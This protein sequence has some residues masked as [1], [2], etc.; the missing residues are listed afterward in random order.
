MIDAALPSEALALARDYD[1]AIDL[2]LTDVVMP[3]MNGVE[4]AKAVRLLR[5]SSVR[6]GTQ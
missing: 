5:P 2:L 4:A 1:G 6:R 3:E